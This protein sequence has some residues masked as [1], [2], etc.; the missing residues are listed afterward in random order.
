MKKILLIMKLVAEVL[1]W[2]E[3]CFHLQMFRRRTEDREDR[4]AIMKLKHGDEDHRRPPRNPARNRYQLR[5]AASDSGTRKINEKP[6]TV[7]KPACKG[8]TCDFSKHKHCNK[9]K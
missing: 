1:N 2:Y 5:L 9:D 4:E 8:N 7:I 6:K 3:K